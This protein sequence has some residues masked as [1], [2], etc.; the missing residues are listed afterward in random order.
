MPPRTPSWLVAAAAAGALIVSAAAEAGEPCTGLAPGPAH[1]VT[2][3]SDGETVTLDNGRELRLIGALAPRAIDVG[4]EPGAWPAE[5][6]ATAELRALLVGK[7]I[8][9]GFGGERGD[10]YGRLQA[11]A[12]IR[13]G[14]GRRWVQGHL[15]EQGLARAYVV[16]GNRACEEPL[17]AAERVA[18]EAR[19]GLWADAAYAIKAASRPAELA[20]Y[21]S[22]FQVVEG[23]IA[24]AAQV[25]GAIYLNFGTDWRRSF[26]A[27][28]RRNDRSLL[29]AYAGDP[30]AMA[31]KQV[32][33]RGWLEPR[34]APAIDLS[35][36]GSIELIGEAAAV[37]A[38]PLGRPTGM[39]REEQEKA[40]GLI[41]TGR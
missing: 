40:P 24:G 4:A 17:L 37:P 8:E 3:V 21:R 7:S 38:G 31:G 36:G 22:T 32:R 9:L 39:P 35:K 14:D 12:F 29:G 34:A 41:E 23:T 13:E 2:D 26:S 30:K 25:R 15:L 19:R 18:R 1:S 28:L 10:R 11:H 20:R 16:P 27:S 5:I 6:A 33:V